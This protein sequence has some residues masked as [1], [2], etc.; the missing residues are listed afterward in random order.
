M[1][2]DMPCCHLWSRWNAYRNGVFEEGGAV[3]GKKRGT[4]QLPPG[5]IQ[6]CV[7]VGL[8]QNGICM[9]SQSIRV[10]LHGHMRLYP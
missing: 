4:P 2:F 1:H 9:S 5:V 7:G 3:G 6:I 10:Y 8:T